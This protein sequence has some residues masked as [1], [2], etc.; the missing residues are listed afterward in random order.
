MFMPSPLLAG[1]LVTS[2]SKG[3][4]ARQEPQTQIATIA[5]GLTADVCVIGHTVRTLKSG[6]TQ[7]TGLHP[8]TDSQPFI[9]LEIRKA[10]LRSKPFRVGA[11]VDHGHGGAGLKTGD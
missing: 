7:Q 11:N 2:I 3:I 6:E 5:S 9:Y 10:Q 1:S 4:R 8:P